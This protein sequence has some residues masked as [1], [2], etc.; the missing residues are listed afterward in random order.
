MF[1]ASPRVWFKPVSGSRHSEGFSEIVNLK[2]LEADTQPMKIQMP[3][4]QNTDILNYVFI[5][6]KQAEIMDS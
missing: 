5:G 1:Q 6:K 4:K 3:T 2:R